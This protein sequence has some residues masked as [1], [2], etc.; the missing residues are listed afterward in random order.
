MFP[1]LPMKKSALLAIAP[2]V[3][4]SL[5]AALG[6]QAPAE[7]PAGWAIPVSNTAVQNLYRVE[8]D[9]LRSAAPTSTGFKE[10]ASL[11]IKTVLDLRGG[12]G[13]SEQARGTPLKLLHVPMTAWWFRDDRVLAA[14]KIL[15]DAKN[16]PL[17]VHC[18]H[19]ADRTGAILALY[20]VVVQGW[21]KA[22]AIREMNQGG[23]HHN[24]AFSNLDN[25][26][27]RADIAA[28]RR[29]LGL[30]APVASLTGR[31]LASAKSAALP[32]AAPAALRGPAGLLS[33]AL[34]PGL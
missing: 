1:L 32:A 3:L 25:Y 24:S 7:R 10:L 34:G 14:L 31:S 19:G 6:G 21:S 18:Q 2:M 5:G 30:A 33:S 16:R 26:V 29:A 27:A 17:L 28:L 8:D 22:D 9:L 12:D 13:D 11:G 20:R 4:V 15:A 23:F